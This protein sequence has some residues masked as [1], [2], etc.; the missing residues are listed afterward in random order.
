M[1]FSTFAL[2]GSQNHDSVEHNETDE[3]ALPESF[4]L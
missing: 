3:Q 4:M 2:Q 1:G